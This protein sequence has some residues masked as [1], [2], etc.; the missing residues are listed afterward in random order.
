MRL[1]FIASVQ[2]SE[3]FAWLCICNK[4]LYSWECN[5]CVHT[6]VYL[7]RKCKVLM[8]L[9][10]WSSKRKFTWQIRYRATCNCMGLRKL[11]YDYEVYYEY[12]NYCLH[13]SEV[14]KLCDTWLWRCVTKPGRTALWAGMPSAIQRA[15]LPS[16]ILRAGLPSAILRTG[17]SSAMLRAGMSSAY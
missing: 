15:G 8:W 12:T 4:A 2:S 5:Y 13:Y 14:S 7:H 1:F 3:W 9:L 10:R 17:L 11:D 16:A 6:Q